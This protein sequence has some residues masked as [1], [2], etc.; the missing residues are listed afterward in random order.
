MTTSRFLP[1]LQL[2]LIGFKGAEMMIKKKIIKNK[3]VNLD[4]DE[5]IFDF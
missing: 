2:S 4:W 5:A 1:S 3:D